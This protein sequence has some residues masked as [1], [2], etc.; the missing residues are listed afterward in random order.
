MRGPLVNIN[1]RH[2]Q[3]N[4][5]NRANLVS[6]VSVTIRFLIMCTSTIQSTIAGDPHGWTVEPLLSTGAQPWR[7]DEIGREDRAPSR[8]RRR[9]AAVVWNK[10]GGERREHGVASGLA[11]GEQLIRAFNLSQA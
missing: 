10:I 5:M 1:S 4:Q 6:R 3:S 9:G 8:G 2:T 11:L 7:S